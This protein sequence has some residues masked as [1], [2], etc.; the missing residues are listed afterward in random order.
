MRIIRLFTKLDIYELSLHKFIYSVKISNMQLL[1]K[2][3]HGN[4]LMMPV[5]AIAWVFVRNI[6]FLLPSLI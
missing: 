6:H 2:S 1:H 3:T 4:N 5:W